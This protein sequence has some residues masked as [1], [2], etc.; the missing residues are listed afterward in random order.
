MKCS[1]C[2]F[3]IEPARLET[4]PDTCVCSSCA[5]NGKGQVAMKGVMVFGHKTG[6]SIQVISPEAFKD[7]RKYNPYGRYTGR[8]SGIHRVTR[9][10]SSI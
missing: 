7:W 1:S 5:R 2:N 10:T 9:S 3:D 8:G 4:L 6:G